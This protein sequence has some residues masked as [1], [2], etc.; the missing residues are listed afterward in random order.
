M[1]PFCLTRSRICLSC[2]FPTSSQPSKLASEL[3]SGTSCKSSESMESSEYSDGAT[4]C[5]LFR[6]FCDAVSLS[7]LSSD[8]SG[9]SGEAGREDAGLGVVPLDSFAFFCEKY[10]SVQPVQAEV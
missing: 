3:N 2:L 6:D 5:A 10:V 1:A 7:E 8:T 4:L 9:S